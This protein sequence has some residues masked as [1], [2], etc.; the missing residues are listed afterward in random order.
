[1]KKILVAIDY[2]FASINAARYA[3]KLGLEIRAQL[4]LLNV[5]QLPAAYAQL[6]GFITS[7]EMYQNAESEIDAVKYELDILADHKL[8][9]TTLLKTG[10][11]FELLKQTCED[12]D[13]DLVIMGS[14]GT[15]ASERLVLGGHS[16]YAMIHLNWPL[17]TVPVKSSYNKIRKIALA[18]DFEN[19][20]ESIPVSSITKLVDMF[21]AKLYIVNASKIGKDTPEFFYQA[22]ILQK[23]MSSSESEIDF[24]TVDN[25]DQGIIDFAAKKEIDL[26]IV[27]PNRRDLLQA[28]FHKSNTKQFVL[29]CHLPVMALH[30]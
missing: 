15:T 21:H 11:F 4:I 20:V 1:M 25:I 28:L 8:D 22:E 14:Q 13:P 3:V 26:L 16:V 30:Y 12:L 9:I 24:I 10:S 6:P 18:C 23:A 27:L 5:Y 29:H 17:I 2:S 19:M 7:E